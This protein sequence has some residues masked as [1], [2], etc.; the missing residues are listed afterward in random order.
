MG[1]FLFKLEEIYIGGL[2]TYIVTL[3]LLHGRE[4]RVFQGNHR[5]HLLFL[6]A[7]MAPPP[8]SIH[9]SSHVHAMVD[10]IHCWDIFSKAY[11]YFHY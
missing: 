4:V 7:S 8:D 11:F 3:C 10:S 1:G 9:Q 2:V 5:Y 6:P